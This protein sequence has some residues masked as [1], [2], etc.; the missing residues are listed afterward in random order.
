MHVR[1][2]CVKTTNPYETQPTAHTLACPLPVEVLKI[3]FRRVY[4][5]LPHLAL[6]CKNWKEIV[7][8][9]Q[10]RET[11]RPALSFGTPE[12]KEYIGVEAGEEP[13]LPR[14]VYCDIEKGNFLLTF[15]PKAVKIPK[16][17]GSSGEVEVLPL[18]S[19]KVIENLLKIQ[20]HQRRMVFKYYFTQLLPKKQNIVKPHW[21]LI[22]NEVLEKNKSYEDH[23]KVA[24]AKDNLIPNA[25]ISGLMD[26]VISVLMERVRSGV[27]NY[28]GD[29]PLFKTDWVHV[30]EL[31]MGRHLALGMDPAGLSLECEGLGP[32]NNVGF[33]LSWHSSG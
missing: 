14:R 4:S 29:L 13:I 3:I 33:Y 31:Y 22:K 16:T 1:D 17:N 19:L 26:T 9:K 11:I 7:D 30:D 21:V 25:N 23:K 8:D 2:T 5:H 24:K 32:C 20:K 28:T 18:D 15:I 12:W 10:F 27:Q 6:V